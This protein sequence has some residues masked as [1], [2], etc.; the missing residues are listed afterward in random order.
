MWEQE[1][2]VGSYMS[3]II[4]TLDCGSLTQWVEIMSNRV[5]RHFF[6]F[7]LFCCSG[8]VANSSSSSLIRDKPTTAS[9]KKKEKKNYESKMSHQQCR[10][11]WGI[12]IIIIIITQFIVR[13]SDLQKFTNFFFFL[14]LG[15]SHNFFAGQRSR[16]SHP[17]LRNTATATTSTHWISFAHLLDSDCHKFLFISPPITAVITGRRGGWQFSTFYLL[18]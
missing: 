1:I 5:H 8:N 11:L 15:F 2:V 14:F 13:I 12:I 3:I 4:A 17:K 7:F 9:K 6:F 10:A 16:P 18:I